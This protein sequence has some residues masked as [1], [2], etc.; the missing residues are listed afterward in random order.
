M[1]KKD[2]WYVLNNGLQTRFRGKGKAGWESKDLPFSIEYTNEGTC[3][4]GE[5]FTVS[6]ER[7][8]RDLIA[9]IGHK[10]AKVSG[11]GIRAAKPFKSGNKEN[12]VKG[13][14]VSQFTGNTAFKFHEDD[15]VVDCNI[16]CITQFINTGN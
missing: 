4:L 9:M 3:N 16:C 11:D 14:F 10:V 12:T 15:S 7:N 1:I 2:I 6:H 13:V 8:E 5:F